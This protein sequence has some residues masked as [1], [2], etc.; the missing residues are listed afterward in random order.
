MTTEFSDAGRGSAGIP[1]TRIKPIS[2]DISIHQ[3]A[4]GGSEELNFPAKIEQK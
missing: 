3:G 4:K 1:A 2:E